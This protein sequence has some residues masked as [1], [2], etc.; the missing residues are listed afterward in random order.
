[1]LPCCD[2]QAFEHLIQLGVISPV[3]ASQS[4]S[5]RTMKQFRL[6]TLEITLD[7]IKEAVEKYPDCPTNIL[8][9]L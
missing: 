1:M 5:K 4:N 7:Q 9:W 6:M 8:K 2:T 3:S